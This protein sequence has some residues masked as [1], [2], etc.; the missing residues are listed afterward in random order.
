MTSGTPEEARRPSEAGPDGRERRPAPLGGGATVRGAGPQAGRDAPLRGS[1]EQGA[2]GCADEAA[3][4]PA[5]QLSARAM[6]LLMPMHLRVDA[7]GTITSVGPTL[8]R[9]C[10][11]TPLP[12]RDFF[13]VFTLRR[14][15]GVRDVA[16]LL[17]ADGRLSLGFRTGARTSFKGLAVPLGTGAGALV[18]LGFGISVVEAVRQYALSNSDFAA[19]DL[20]VELLY[21]VEAN[22]AALEESRRLNLRLQGAKSAAEAQAITDT[23]TGLG[24]RRAMDEV[25]TRLEEAGRGFGLIH[26]DLDFFKDV[27]DRLGHAAG[28]AVLQH[29]GRVLVEETRGEDIVTRAGGDEFI[30]IFPRVTDDTVLRQ[31]ALRIIARIEKP[32]PHGDQQCLISASAGIAVSRGIG[33][34]AQVLLDADRALYASKARGRAQATVASATP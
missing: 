23:L 8:Q 31:L 24:N 27:N 1:A 28:D 11:E 9:I 32:I 30:L 34:V 25:L 10:A 15:Q 18:N 29:V 13:D 21:L 7:C 16:G 22:T 17:R 3:G 4:L 20:A 14:P 19:T 12:G 2:R 33:S 26:L 6:D 5:P